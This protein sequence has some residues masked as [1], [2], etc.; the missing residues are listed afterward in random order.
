MTGV[1]YEAARAAAF[2]GYKLI[3]DCEGLEVRHDT[4]GQIPRF[5]DDRW[6]GYLANLT[7]SEFRSRYESRLPESMT[8]AEYMT[9]SSD[10]KAQIHVDPFTQMRPEVSYRVRAC[11]RYSVEENCR[12]RTFVELARGGT[13]FEEMGELLY[14]AHWSYTECGLGCKET[15]QIIELVRDEGPEN[16]LFGA[17]ITGG[18][19]G[20][21]VAV[22]GYKTARHAFDRVIARYADLRGEVPYVF[23]GS[24]M[25]ADRFGVQVVYP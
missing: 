8:G 22:L 21:T 1:E 5:V 3:C 10:N 7:P 18:G 16:G 4:S 13:G 14:Q 24:S 15:D 6:N 2:M 9:A 17:K 20:G 12:V 11:T 19:A 25:G 23:E